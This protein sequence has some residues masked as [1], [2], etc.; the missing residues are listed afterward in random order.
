MFLSVLSQLED[1]VILLSGLNVNLIE[2][3]SKYNDDY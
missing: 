1:F 2:G 3:V